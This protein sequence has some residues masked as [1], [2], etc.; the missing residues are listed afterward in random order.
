MQGFFLYTESGKSI[1][2][3]YNSIYNANKTAAPAAK[4]ATNNITSNVAVVLR[5][6]NRGDNVFLVEGEGSNVH[7]MISDKLAIYAED[8]LAQVANSNLIGT[9]LTIKTNEATEYTLSFAWLKGEI[10]YL[11]DLVNGNIIAMTEDT[12]YT[13][14]AEPNTVSERFQVIGRNNVVTGIENSAAIEGAN[15]FIENG[16]VVIIKNG[17]KYN[18]L[19]AQL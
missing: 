3:N 9:M 8:G 19:G 4:R 7:K 18:V 10:L 1:T 5:G 15:K 11:K 14:T 16:K 13:F 17:V 2:L 6:G 12:N